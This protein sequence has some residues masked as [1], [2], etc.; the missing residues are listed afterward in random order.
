MAN[1]WDELPDERYWCEVTDRPDIGADLKSPQADESGK[2][3]W[4]YSLLREVWPGDIVFH[5]S[6]PQ[7]APADRGHSRPLQP[8]LT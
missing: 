8:S 4:S 5:Y 6:K 2:K 3:Q 7:K 1:W